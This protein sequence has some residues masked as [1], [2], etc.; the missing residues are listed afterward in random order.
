MPSACVVPRCKGNYKKGPK[1]HVFGFPTDSDCKEKWIRAIRRENFFPSKYSKVIGFEM[2]PCI[3]FLAIGEFINC[4][5]ELADRVCA[6]HQQYYLPTVS[7][8]SSIS[9]QA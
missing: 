7:T 9:K 6:P 1:V 3:K 2:V 8:C 4:M 5:Y